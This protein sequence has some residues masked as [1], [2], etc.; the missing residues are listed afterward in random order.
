MDMSDLPHR[1]GVFR[2]PREVRAPGAQDATA[3]S[4]ANDGVGSQ[5]A[6]HVNRQRPAAA[7]SGSLA[8]KNSFH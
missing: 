3:R 2:R 6:T 7:A 8:I 1:D 5:A 4:A